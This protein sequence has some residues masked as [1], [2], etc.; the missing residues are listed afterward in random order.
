[1]PS[2]SRLWRALVN[3]ANGSQTT[4][5]NNNKSNPKY[6]CALLRSQPVFKHP[7]LIA[8]RPRHLSRGRDVTAD[9]W[10]SRG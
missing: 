1:M 2:Y 5:P 3:L 7:L 9:T 10:K 4:H 8:Q 6:R